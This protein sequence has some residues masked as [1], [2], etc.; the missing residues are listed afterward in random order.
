M[1]EQYTYSDTAQAFFYDSTIVPFE[2]AILEKLSTEQY[3]LQL[4]K[5]MKKLKPYE[6]EIIFQLFWNRKSQNELAINYGISQQTMNEKVN[7][8]LVKMLKMIKIEK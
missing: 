6:R 3:V 5:I 7:R 2:E 1:L 8:I 4:Q